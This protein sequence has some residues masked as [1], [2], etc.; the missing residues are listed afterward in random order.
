LLDYVPDP[1]GIYVP[2]D[3]ASPP[4]P[5]ITPYVSSYNGFSIPNFFAVGDQGTV[6]PLYPG[7]ID[8]YGT[9]ASNATYTILEPN[10]LVGSNL[11][12]MNASLQPVYTLEMDILQPD[13]GAIGGKIVL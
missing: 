3:S 2:R 6:T 7:S 4:Q 1:N 12:F 13:T 9:G 10:S 11:E 8:G 5:H